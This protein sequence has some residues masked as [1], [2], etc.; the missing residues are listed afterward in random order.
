M[1]NLRTRRV[2]CDEQ[3]PACQRCVATKR[4]CEGY[5][6]L[7]RGVSSTS[8]FLD[9]ER[10]GLQI[11]RVRTAQKIFGQQDASNWIP[12]I[13]QLGHAEPA[14]RHAITAL[15]SLHESIEPINNILTTGN[16]MNRDTTRFTQ[17]TALKHYSQA[18]Q[19][20]RN[21]DMYSRPDLTL[22]I[23]VLFILFE[24][25]RNGDA[26]CIV[27]LTA[28][29]RL[30]YWWRE[31]TNNYA[32]LKDYSRPTL[33]FINEKMTPVLQRLRV[34]FSLCMDSRHVMHNLG[35]KY[36]LPPP[37]IPSSYPSFDAARRDFDRAMNYIFSILEN[38]KSTGHQRPTQ[39]PIAIL[40][41][42]R[43]SVSASQAMTESLAVQNCTRSLLELYYQ[44][45]VIIICTYYTKTEVAF[46]NYLEQFQTIIQLA[47]N[48][49]SSWN[50]STSE[51]NLLFSFD[52]GMTPPMF[53]VASRCRHPEVRRRAAS[54]L[55][56]SPFYHGAWRDRYSGLCAQRIIRIEEEGFERVVTCGD[57]PEGSR[58]RKVSADIQEEDRRIVMHFQRAP[59]LPDSPVCT[60]YVSLD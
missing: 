57:I 40:N 1:T 19:C 2:K 50:L 35:I 14:V 5:T 37:S 47:E 49:V 17:I 27:H 39:D 59:F 13:L 52:L 54:L 20:L 53:L 16:M 18:I 34:Q 9:E 3:K 46:D 4:I 12:T 38:D 44:V 45:A 10:R 29:L 24:Q 42:W 28:G 51:Y 26:E 33:E 48:I 15:A 41:H 25:F 55:L 6:F 56:Q 22:I 31:R 30:I 21:D 8:N 43:D 32:K 23:C 60:T 36:Y 7:N 11:F 58:V